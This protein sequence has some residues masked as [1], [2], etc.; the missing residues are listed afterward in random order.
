M[1][2]KTRHLRATLLHCSSKQR[3]LQDFFLVQSLAFIRIGFRSPQKSQA[4]PPSS[5]QKQTRGTDKTCPFPSTS[6]LMLSPATETEN[7]FQT[8]PW[9]PG[10]LLPLV[11]LSR[12][13]FQSH[14]H[15]S[16]HVLLVKYKKTRQHLEIFMSRLHVTAGK[17]R[18]VLCMPQAK[19][20]SW[21]LFLTFKSG[22]KCR[23]I[24][25]PDS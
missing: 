1:T 18:L 6:P 25:Q 16:F 12:L 23:V 9:S 13:A 24:I 17:T 4:R 15:L 7:Q 22:E 21:L 10:Q 8:W 3:H 5:T 11:Y 19:V 14:L 2:P 20:F